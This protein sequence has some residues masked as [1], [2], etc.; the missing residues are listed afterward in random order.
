MPYIVDTK[1]IS[2]L[3]IDN[4]LSKEKVA[5]VLGISRA[6]YTHKESGKAPF[7]GN[8]IGLLADLFKQEPGFFYTQN[9]H[10]LRTDNT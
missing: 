2:H 3:R 7:K 10:G 1:A 9:V 6:Q 4:H 8:E 5:N